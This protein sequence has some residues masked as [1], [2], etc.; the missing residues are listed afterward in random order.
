MWV[1]DQAGFR[2]ERFSRYFF[3]RKSWGRRRK[4]VVKVILR[5]KREVKEKKRERRRRTWVKRRKAVEVISGKIFT[6]LELEGNL[7]P[8]L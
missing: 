6:F 3:T 8:P 4:V 2:E 7:P 5:R 1:Q